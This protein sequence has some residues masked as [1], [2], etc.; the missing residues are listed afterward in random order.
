MKALVA[1]ILL[2][3]LALPANAQ[4]TARGSQATCGCN[5]QVS[6]CNRPH[7]PDSTAITWVQVEMDPCRSV[8]QHFLYYAVPHGI[9]RDEFRRRNARLWAMAEAG[10][11]YRGG[12]YYIWLPQSSS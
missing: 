9:S 7:I 1:A 4:E 3:M 10:Q 12:R 6:Q 8:W 2:L 5:A 11:L